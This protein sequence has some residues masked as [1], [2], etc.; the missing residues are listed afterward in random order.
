M[1]Y[2]GD[3]RFQIVSHSASPREYPEET[4]ATLQVCVP[5][6]GAQYTVTRHSETGRRIVQH[7]GSSEILIVPPGQP[8]AVTWRRTAFVVSLNMSEDFI[9]EETGNE[10]I[11]LRDTL[12][13]RDPLITS[14]ANLLRGVD[15]DATHG[16]RLARAVATV[17]AHRVVQSANRLG[18]RERPV[19]GAAFSRR[20]VARILEYVDEH[21]DRAICIAELASREGLSRWHFLRRFTTTFASSPR[22]FITRRRLERARALLLQSDLPILKVALEVGMNHSHFSRAFARQFGVQ[23]RHIRQLGTRRDADHDGPPA[24][25]AQLPAIQPR[26]VLE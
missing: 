4:H 22:A 6:R 7:L 21:M 25:D 26:R 15:A 2:L 1:H 17:I 14:A 24:I 3:G 18:R 10:S 13:L 19:E 5:M 16:V 11:R 8:H 20:Q 9:A 12:W 23:P